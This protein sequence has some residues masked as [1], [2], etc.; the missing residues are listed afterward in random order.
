MASPWEVVDKSFKILPLQFYI[1]NV[2]LTHKHNNPHTHARAHKVK[3]RCRPYY[4]RDDRSDSKM[5]DEYCDET[6]QRCSA[7]KSAQDIEYTKCVPGN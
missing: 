7:S 5:L 3:N 1:A 4:E 2:E 6:L